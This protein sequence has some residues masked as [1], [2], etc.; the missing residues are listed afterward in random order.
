[1][2]IYTYQKQDI[3]F[4]RV[5]LLF[6]AFIMSFVKFV[7]CQNMKLTPP[8]TPLPQYNEALGKI[9]LHVAFTLF[10]NVQSFS[11]SLISQIS[12]FT[13]GLEIK[14]CS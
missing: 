6:I 9:R 13:I 4:K 2:S 5:I 1:M 12:K 10:V 7:F 3:Y 11:Y 14:V 8:C